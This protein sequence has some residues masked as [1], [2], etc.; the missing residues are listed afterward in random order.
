MP[1]TAGVP[2]SMLPAGPLNAWDWID[3]GPSGSIG[4]AQQSALMRGT[5]GGMAAYQTRQIQGP[6]TIPQGSPIYVTSR[7]YSRG[8]EAHA[9]RFG[10]LA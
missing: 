6:Q 4:G 2:I 5:P 7:P 1:T 8:A 10:K 3:A 9:P